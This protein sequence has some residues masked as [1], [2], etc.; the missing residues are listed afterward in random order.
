MATLEG[1]LKLNGPVG[2]LSFYT[3]KDGKTI[4][5]SKGGPSREKVLT[6]R[7]FVR[8]RENNAEFAMMTRKAGEIRKAF[9]PY[10][11]YTSEGTYW[12]RLN[13]LL[14]M[15]L[16]TSRPGMR[17]GTRTVF[18]GNIHLLE[19]FQWNAKLSFNDALNIDHFA[20]IDSITGNMK[21]EFPSF[22]PLTAIKA[23]AGA[24]HFQIVIKGTAIH[25]E[26]RW[27]TMV[28]AAGPLTRINGQETSPLELSI[29]PVCREDDGFYMLGAGIIFYDEVMGTP[30]AIRGGAFGIVSTERIPVPA[31]QPASGTAKPSKNKKPPS[32]DRAK[33]LKTMMD[34]F[35]NGSERLNKRM[36]PIRQ[37][38]EE[39]EAADQRRQKLERTL[40]MNKLNKYR[41]G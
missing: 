1:P 13:G 36:F 27:A 30:L 31:Q 8:T 10:Q 16:K 18:D 3:T 12:N 9:G 33:D 5:R 26:E 24:T 2:N 34:R 15:V 20:S 38:P 41:K 21:M 19:D 6:D 32:V 23:P 37:S 40:W 28:D 39:K 22:V 29:K 14:K 7:N 4:A 35:A 11:Q 17:R 25:P